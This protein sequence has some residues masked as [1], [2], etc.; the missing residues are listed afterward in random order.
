MKVTKILCFSAVLPL[1]MLIGAH[2][3]SLM[4]VRFPVKYKELFGDFTKIK[5]TQPI[6]SNS[7]ISTETVEVHQIDHGLRLIDAQTFEGASFGVG[8]VHGTDRLW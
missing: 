2:V 6:L 7:H 8:Y 3:K 1:L 4:K 5:L